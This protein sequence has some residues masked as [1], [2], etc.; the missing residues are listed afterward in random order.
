MN[1]KREILSLYITKYRVSRSQILGTLTSQK[2]TKNKTL[3]IKVPIL[4]LRLAL[5]ICLLENPRNKELITSY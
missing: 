1:N 4:G 5:I 3:A 2:K